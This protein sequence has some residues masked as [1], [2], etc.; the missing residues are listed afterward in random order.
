MKEFFT[1][2]LRGLCRIVLGLV[3]G[4]STVAILV[5]IGIG[6]ILL[7]HYFKSDYWLSLY[8]LHV[9]M[10]LFSIGNDDNVL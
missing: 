8:S 1:T 6:P 5:G 7:A 10:L 9:L 3:C 2:V 4:V